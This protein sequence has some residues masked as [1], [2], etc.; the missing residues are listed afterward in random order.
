MA[1]RTTF[2][3]SAPIGRLDAGETALAER[4]LRLNG[5]CLRVSSSLEIGTVLQEVADSACDLT[6]ARYG[7]L[8][9]FDW[10]GG[11]Q[12]T[13]TSGLDSQQ[14]SRMTTQQV[15]EGLLG[16]LNELEGPLRVADVSKHFRSVGFPEYH[17]PM[18]TF[19]G[20]RVRHDGAHLGNI[21]LG[22]KVDGGEFT[23]LDEQLIDRFAQQAGA[24]ISNARKFERERKIKTDLKALVKIAPVGL[25]VFD[26]RTGA[27]LTSNEECQ[28][29]GGVVGSSAKSWQ[30][31]FE[32]VTMYRA[33]GR[34][35]SVGDRPATQVLQ[36]GE[37][38]RGEEIVLHFSDGRVVNTLI[39]A[40]PIYSD[41]GEIVSVLVAVQDLALLKDAERMRAEHLGMVSHELRMPLTAIKGSIAALT[42]VVES[43]NTV[44]PLQL[45]KIIDH[46]A[47][48]MRG[49]I[50]S[51]IDLSHIEAGALMLSLEAAD[52]PTLAAECVREFRRYHAGF[53][54][55]QDIPD[56]LPPAMADKERVSQI[57]RN[58]LAHSFKYASGATT[59]TMK[60]EHEDTHMMFSVSIDSDRA[61]TGNPPELMDR[62]RSAAGG[63]PIQ[64]YVGDGLALAICK[65]IVEAHGGW[66]R[67]GIQ[68]CG[69][70]SCL[71]FTLPVAEV[72]ETDLSR[73]EGAGPE[74]PTDGYTVGDLV[75][76]YPSRGVTVA[77]QQI[78]L[79]A[80]EYK[81]LYEFSS[82][83][84]RVLT[85]DEL[86]CEV[87][88]PEY[89]GE[90]QLLRAYVK[91]LRQKL[92]DNA[93]NPRYIFTER[94]V[95]YQM[96]RA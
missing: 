19:L 27:V 91:T 12:E 82:K 96:A 30:E 13:V 11:F 2:E 36:S 75:I 84:G 23:E 34:Q 89:S 32:N 24:A 17:P 64:T 47:E 56:D 69:H 38:V 41:R 76:S 39:N 66:F 81:L 90:P 88:G 85:Q 80:T 18:K 26:A 62:I 72:L 68:D 35:L 61:H 6:E 79:T 95:G 33:D 45:L 63:D 46:Q 57:F 14:L 67:S 93:R 49:Q 25:V 51:L 42:E 44:E 43:M 54:V 16:Y 7:V 83:A 52:V 78:Q 70:G 87:W 22:E 37:I 77:G 50:N 9:L 20:A 8:A 28:R 10:S 92:G 65:G 74:S 58:I 3:D 55:N 21:Y 59:I 15:G 86:L 73:Q 53:I 60:A 71:T 29:I 94:G 4:L 40:T 1:T 31:T 48:V 5:A